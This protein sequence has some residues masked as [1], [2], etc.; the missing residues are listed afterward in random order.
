MPGVRRETLRHPPPRGVC[1]LAAEDA[2]RAADDVVRLNP[3]LFKYVRCGFDERRTTKD[4]SIAAHFVLRPSSFVRGDQ[5][6]I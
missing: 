3:I 6:V 5:D 4:E 1:C 2:R